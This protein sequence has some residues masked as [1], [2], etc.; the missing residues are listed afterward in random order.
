MEESKV[1]AGLRTEQKPRQESWQSEAKW[2]TSHSK[3][4][5][6][7]G[8]K[9]RTQQAIHWWI[10]K[11]VQGTPRRWTEQ[12]RAHSTGE[13]TWEEKGSVLLL[14]IFRKSM[15]THTHACAHIHT[16]TEYFNGHL[17]FTFL[18][19]ICVENWPESHATSWCL[20]DKYLKY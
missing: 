5:V 6:K 14:N 3:L 8:M 13:V 7:S 10:W 20:A 16:T 18:L 1:I 4:P 2:G 9:E 17:R 15:C 12:P 11:R 19:T